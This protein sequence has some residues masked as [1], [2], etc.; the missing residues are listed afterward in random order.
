MQFQDTDGY[1]KKLLADVYY[2]AKNGKEYVVYAYSNAFVSR[3]ELRDTE[4]IVELKQRRYNEALKIIRDFMLSKLNVRC[5]IRGHRG[6]FIFVDIRDRIN[7]DG[8][9]KIYNADGT[10]DWSWKRRQKS[11]GK[12]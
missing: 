1:C 12:V 10:P 8:G 3:L 7:S 2:K 6:R 5:G 9:V 4:N 11:A